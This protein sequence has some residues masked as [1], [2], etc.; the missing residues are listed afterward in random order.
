ML[1]DVSVSQEATLEV[2]IDLSGSQKIGM[3][4]ADFQDGERNVVKV[5]RSPFAPLLMFAYTSP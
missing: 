4:L 2:Q 3:S 1:K 5:C